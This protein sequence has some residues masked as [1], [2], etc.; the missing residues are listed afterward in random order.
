MSSLKRTKLFASLTDRLDLVTYA[1]RC[2]KRGQK[3]YKLATRQYA[4]KQR[5]KLRQETNSKLNKCLND[6]QIAISIDEDSIRAIEQ[7]RGFSI[8]HAQIPDDFFDRWPLV[9]VTP[10]NHLKLIICLDKNAHFEP[11][12]SITDADL[13]SV[14]DIVEN[15][16]EN[17]GQQL[18]LWRALVL[19]GDKVRLNGDNPIKV[20]L[21]SSQ[22]KYKFSLLK[23]IFETMKSD[24]SQVNPKI[25]LI[26]R[27]DLELLTKR[28]VII[29]RALAKFERLEACSLEIHKCLLGAYSDYR[30]QTHKGYY[31]DIDGSNLSSVTSSSLSSV[32]QK[33]Q[34]AT[35]AIKPVPL[36]SMP[37]PVRDRLIDLSG[38]VELRDL[39][40][41][42]VRRSMRQRISL[43]EGAAGTGKTVVAANLACQLSRLR[44]RKVLLCSPVQ[45]TVDK[46]AHMIDTYGGDL[47]VVQLPLDRVDLIEP[48][49]SMHL[50]KLGRRRRPSNSSEGAASARNACLL[51]NYVDH[52]IYQRA[53]SKFQGLYG[54]GHRPNQPG[55]DYLMWKRQRAEL[56]KLASRSLEKCSDWLRQRME[57]RMVKEADIVCC[58]LEQAG[59]WLLKGVHFD[60]LIID[61]AHV[62]SELSCLVALTAPGLKQVTLLSDV[63]LNI[64]LA[65]S[66][67]NANGRNNHL[68]HR[69][70]SVDRLT[71]SARRSKLERHRSFSTGKSKDDYHAYDS[72][73]GD[74]GNLF[75]RLLSIGLSTVALRYQYRLHETLAEFTNRHFYLNRL[76]NDPEVNGQLEELRAMKFASRRGQVQSDDS[77]RSLAHEIEEVSQQFSWLPN[78]N[79][80]TALFDCQKDLSSSTSVDSI[81]DNLAQCLLDVVDNLLTKE[82]VDDTAIIIL[83]NSNRLIRLLNQRH[84]STIAAK[85]VDLTTVDK[86]IGQ[87]QDFVILI[88]APE[89][90]L[91]RE[92][93]S[94]STRS[95]TLTSKLD[96]NLGVDCDYLQNDWALNIALTRGRFGLFI[97]T[98]LSSMLVPE[99]LELT[100]K[101]V[102][103]TINEEQVDNSTTKGQQEEQKVEKSENNNN[104]ATSKSKRS[105][106]DQS[107]CKSWRRLV[108][109]YNDTELIV[110]RRDETTSPSVDE[111][112]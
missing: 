49:Q 87:E 34:S 51:D 46:L 42:A 38:M 19:E 30:N 40:R 71:S 20:K 78:P 48:H 75:E 86:Y 27:P 9:A 16:P 91:T 66:R 26:L 79:Y 104:S 107:I 58:T 55:S 15:E 90:V 89:R 111:L 97:V 35:G 94:T 76:K 64:R 56:E 21:I 109:Y 84:G 62:A 45:A 83:A 95:S 69:S 81:V 80:L 108:G 99:S 74:T 88:G 18:K 37:T 47:L 41:Q 4:N 68:D 29:E 31:N 59:S 6:F 10:E 103:N 100:D 28:Q 92:G 50:A 53:I 98:S 44:R 12:K 3:H 96:S 85:H 1:K 112:V 25:R 67:Y 39:Q 23:S 72:Y 22:D 77:E 54:E 65:R 105:K 101:T 2:I 24:A 110:Q 5:L 106:F 7:E 52:A 70:K 73:E 17:K 102:A 33:M 8:A 93:S 60:A 43:I 14:D 82:C 61:D 36:D 32:T 11:Q 63:R 13:I 57:R